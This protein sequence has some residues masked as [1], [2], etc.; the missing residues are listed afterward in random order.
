MFETDRSA[1]IRAAIDKLERLGFR[2]F[3]VCGHCAG[4]YHAFR[5]AITEPRLSALVLLNL[6]AA[7]S[8]TTSDV[9]ISHRKVVTVAHYIRQ[10]AKP[11]FWMRLMAGK[12]PIRII[13][14]ARVAKVADRIRRAGEWATR[15]GKSDAPAAGAAGG[16]MALSRRGVRTLFLFTEGDLG[17]QVL[18]E[19][20]GMVGVDEA[21]IMVIPGGDHAFSESAT[22]QVAI[23]EMI[24]FLLQR[25][26]AQPAVPPQAARVDSPAFSH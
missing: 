2:R 19:E 17:R 18:H 25:D 13:L 3:A 10:F 23:G 11:Y 4:A 1:E 5:A 20:L 12:V 6:P 15:R 8:S 14:K 7:T 16:L 26:G 22:Q 21:R 24:D 9:E